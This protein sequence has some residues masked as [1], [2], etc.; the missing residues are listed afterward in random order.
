[1][2]FP[3]SFFLD[4][5]WAPN[6]IPA[7]GLKAYTRQWAAQQFGSEHAT[8]ITEYLTLYTKYNGRRKPELLDQNTYSLVNYH[9]FEG[10]VQDYKRLLNSA[11]TLAQ[12]L[13]A[14][15]QDAFYELVLHPIQACANLNEMYFEAAKNKLYAAQGRAVTNITADQVTALFKKDK[16]ISNHYNKVLAGGKWDHMMD[17]T[18]IGYTNWQQPTKDE[19]PAVTRLT[20]PEK[21]EIGLSTEGSEK[22]WKAGTNAAKFPV[23]YPTDK[24]PHSFEVFNRGQTPFK[25]SAVSSAAYVQAVPESGLIT[26]QQNIQLKIDYAKA[27]KGRSTVLIKIKSEAG[28]LELTAILDNPKSASKVFMETNGFISIEASHFSKKIDAGK[29]KWEVL[30]EYGRTFE[31]IAPSPVTSARQQAGGNSPHLEYNINLAD[32]GTIAL[33]TYL[34]PTINFKGHGGLLYAV[35]VDQERPQVIDINTIADSKDWEIAVG[36]NIRKMVTKHHIR[37]AGIHT[38]KYWMV[39]PGVVLQKLVIDNGGLQKSYLGPPGQ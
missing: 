1:M 33:H 29:I 15:Q 14:N 31:G 27:P 13:P 11:Q 17:Q 30:P 22:W 19:M 28:D 35:S 4:Y 37:K 3:I 39:D 6:R 23:F 5:A 32:T 24:L 16:E 9:E 12:K 38:V 2:E 10:V 21:A 18:H 26:N 20:L 25:F 36:E 7:S 8:E 34:S